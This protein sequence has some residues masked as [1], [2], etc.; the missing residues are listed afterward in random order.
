VTLIADE[1]QRAA[2][3]R[4]DQLVLAR[5]RVRL[6]AATLAPPEPY[7]AVRE[8][9]RPVE[10]ALLEAQTPMSS[11]DEELELIEDRR[12]PYGCLIP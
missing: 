7:A 5:T 9:W 8:A 10:L 6:F 12:N 3:W 2:Q 1:E 4:A 11:P